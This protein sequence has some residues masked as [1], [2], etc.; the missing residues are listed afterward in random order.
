MNRI[1]ELDKE[2]TI[3]MKLA[4]GINTNDIVLVHNVHD[5]DKYEIIQIESYDSETNIITFKTK[6]FSNYAIALKERS[7]F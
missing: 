4:D 1:D 2:T 5:G 7:L 6:S 3:T